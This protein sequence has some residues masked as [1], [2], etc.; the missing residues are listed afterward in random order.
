MPQAPIHTEKL[1]EHAINSF[2]PGMRNTSGRRVGLLAPLLQPV[3]SPHGQTWPKL[4]LEWEETSLEQTQTEL[5][6]VL[7]L[8][9][10]YCSLL[11]Y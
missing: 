1:A 8:V 11:D 4:T 2:P 5:W 7:V 6:S 3:P 10:E 9:I